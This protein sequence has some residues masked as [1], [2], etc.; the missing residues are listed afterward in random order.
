M[1]DPVIFLVFSYTVKTSKTNHTYQVPRTHIIKYNKNNF[2]VFSFL[3]CLFYS[4]YNL[5][6][7]TRTSLGLLY[8]KLCDWNTDTAN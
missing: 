5:H 7:E 6:S 2:I 4:W 3:I 1:L 8:R